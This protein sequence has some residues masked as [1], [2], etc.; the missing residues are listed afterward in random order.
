MQGDNGR[1]M[2]MSVVV[3]TTRG[4]ITNFKSNITKSVKT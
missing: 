1:V 2:S 3:Y 4:S